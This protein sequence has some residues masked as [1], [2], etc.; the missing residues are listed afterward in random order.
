MDFF[1]VFSRLEYGLK[2]L[3]FVRRGPGGRAECDW[4]EYASSIDPTLAN[5]PSERL[6]SAIGYLINEPPMVQLYDHGRAVWSEIPLRGKTV[7]ERAFE[8]AR[9]VRNNLFHGGK[10][11]KHSPAGRDRQ[12]VASALTLFESCLQNDNSLRRVYEEP[13]V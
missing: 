2:E 11:S 1:A 6:K 12:L 9:R 7:T 10:H 4:P 8:S 13:S 5:K 3:G